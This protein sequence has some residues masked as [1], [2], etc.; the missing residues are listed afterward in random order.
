MKKKKQKKYKYQKK[1]KGRK[2]M[3]IDNA[4]NVYQLQ[5]ISGPLNLV[6]EFKSDL[7]IDD[8]AESFLENLKTGGV[9]IPMEDNAR[10]VFGP[11]T[12]IN[13]FTKEQFEKMQRMSQIAQPSV[14]G[15]P[16]MR[17]PR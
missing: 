14:S 4:E 15:M 11:N 17:R 5:V 12:C 13:I 1:R 2:I 7:N 6:T 16:Q 8:L 9:V 10:F 3:K